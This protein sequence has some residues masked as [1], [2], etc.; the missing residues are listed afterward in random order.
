MHIKDSVKG[1]LVYCNYARQ[2]DIKDIDL[3]GAIAL[4]KRGIDKGEM[5]FYEKVKNAEAKGAI[6]CIIFNNIPGPLGGYLVS[7]DTK[8]PSLAV[9][10]QIGAKLKIVAD[11]GGECEMTEVSKLGYLADFTSAGPTNDFRLKP[12]VSA[13]GVNVLS[14]VGQN[15]YV[16]M[17]GTSMACPAVAGASALVIQAHPDWNAHDVRSA[18]INYANPQSD[19]NGKLHPVLAQGTGRV[20]CIASINAP[21]IFFP[22]ALDFGFIKDKVSGSLRVKNASDKILTFK[23]SLSPESDDSMATFTDIMLKPGEKKDYPVVINPKADIKDGSH[24]GYILF[25]SGNTV[26]R[27]AYLYFTG[28]KP[29]PPTVSHLR[30]TTP[31]FSPNDDGKLDSL[32]ARISLNK[33]LM[34]Y[35]IDLTDDKDRLISIWDFGIGLMGGGMWDFNWDGTIEGEVLEPGRYRMH[36]YTLQIGKDPT[37]KNDWEHNGPVEFYIAQDPPQIKFNLIEQTIYNQNNP[38]TISGSIDDLLSNPGMLG[39]K[40]IKKLAVQVN[41]KEMAIELED[42]GTFSVDLNLKP[43]DNILKFIARNAGDIEGIQVLTVKLLKR[44]MVI[45]TIN[46]ITVDGKVVPVKKISLA[47]E[48]LMIDLDSFTKIIPDIK[49]NISG[50]V[51]TVNLDNYVI[52]LKVGQPFLIVNGEASFCEPPKSFEKSAL[53]PIGAILES[54]GAKTNGMSW[55]VIWRGD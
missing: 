37:N 6:G 3:I 28:E 51:I 48:E 16:R 17:S 47:N 45:G 9:S 49:A 40:G 33:M 14:A 12:D 26:A 50:Q 52:S 11:S 55:D 2:E 20:D 18:I 8:I 44:I 10:D 54:I 1:K 24:S 53:I 30:L 38:L 39:K 22:T 32:R 19:A 31:V 34:G 25:T 15:S 35:E 46:N 5:T 42:D 43:G 21:A 36:F 13:P 41:E 29:D 27:V 4:I 7:S 23:I